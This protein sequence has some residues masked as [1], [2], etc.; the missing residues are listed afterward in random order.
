LCPVICLMGSLRECSL[1]SLR[2]SPCQVSVTRVLGMENCMPGISLD[3]AQPAKKRH[4][5]SS[6]CSKKV[7]A[8]W[9][10]AR[11]GPVWRCVLPR[12]RRSRP[13]A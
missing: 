11:A 12:L 8:Y 13:L 7:I 3:E 2:P 1:R 5:A 10:S 6:F 4:I 9:K